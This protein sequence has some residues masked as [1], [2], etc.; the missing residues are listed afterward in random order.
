MAGILLNRLIEL[1]ETQK[2]ESPQ[3][4]AFSVHTGQKEHCW[5]LNKGGTTL[6]SQASWEAYLPLNTNLSFLFDHHAG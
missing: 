4:W 3:M 6:K 2:K 1:L 5:N